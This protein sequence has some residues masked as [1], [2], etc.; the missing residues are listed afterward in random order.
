MGSSETEQQVQRHFREHARSFDDLYE[1]ERALQRLLRPGLFRRRELALA[2]V[3]S[4]PAPRVLDVGCGS[5]RIGELILQ[6]GAREWVGVDF[7]EPML[8]LAAARLERFGERVRLVHG[9]F[10]GAPLSGPFEVVVAVGLF[11]YLPDAKRFMARM[12]ELCAPDGSLVASFPAW[13][14]L[15]GPLRRLRYEWINRC[16]IFNYT[17]AQLNELL[18]EAGFAR[19]EVARGRAGFLTRSWR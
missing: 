17:E 8:E 7:S 4:H 13:T 5:G 9:D 3:R 14:P 11:D 15:K 1:D 16:P 18:G 12:A 6:A 2:A 10:L 19:T